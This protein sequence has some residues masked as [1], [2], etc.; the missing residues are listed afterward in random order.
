MSFQNGVAGQQLTPEDRFAND[1]CD[2]GG[3]RSTFP[4]GVCF[5]LGILMSLR[6]HRRPPNLQARQRDLPTPGVAPDFNS[7][8]TDGDGLP[9]AWERLHGTNPSLA[10]ATADPDG[11]GLDN[12]AEF[13]AGT[14]PQDP[15]SGVF[16]DATAAAPD[17]LLLRFVAAPDRIHVLQRRLGPEGAWEFWRQF[18]PE[19]T[20]RSIEVE[21]TVTDAGSKWYR[22]SVRIP[23]R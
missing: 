19:A 23:V 11:D 21:D 1:G 4:R 2:A 3:S 20:P 8:D 12:L 17:R 7:S 18:E 9:D 15:A 10:D 14:D 22:L 13:N 5:S 6:Y 16:L